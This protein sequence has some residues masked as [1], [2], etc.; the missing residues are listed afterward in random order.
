MPADHDARADLRAALV[1]YMSGDIKTSAFDDRNSIYFEELA[2]DDRSVLEISRR[3]YNLH[4]DFIDHPISV[5]CE[6]WQMLK[7]VLAFLNTDLEIEAA[8]TT[9]SWPFRDQHEWL[10]N[11]HFVYD[12]KIPE[13]D[14]EIH[15]RR[16][17]FWWN[18]IPA[19]VGFSIILGLLVVAAFIFKILP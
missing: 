10:T 13:Y 7:R 6:C 14:P 4:D 9:Q 17:Q 15:S 16:Y 8:A 12:C 2:T 18:R 1:S 11:E 3:L 19:A 5:T